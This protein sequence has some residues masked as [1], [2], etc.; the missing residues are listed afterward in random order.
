MLAMR[1]HTDPGNPGLS[2]RLRTADLRGDRLLGTP[3]PQVPVVWERHRYGQGDCELR[4][5]VISA[6]WAAQLG[7]DAQHAGYVAGAVVDV[8]LTRAGLLSVAPNFTSDDSKDLGAADAVGTAEMREGHPSSCIAGPNVV[9]LI[10]SQFGVPDLLA[11]QATILAG[12]TF[13]DF[14]ANVVVVR[15]Q[16]QVIGAHTGRVVAVVQNM[17]ASRDRPVSNDDRRD[18]RAHHPF[19]L[20]ANAH[21]AVPVCGLASGPNPTR[22]QLRTVRRNR[23]VQINAG[24]EAF[25]QSLSGLVAGALPTFN[26]AVTACLCL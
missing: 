16:K 9:D 18:V 24:P 15:A 8:I 4:R 13:L 25:S 11:T 19:P 2:G 23:P 26:R 22:P 14:I 10:A 3:A 17:H 12:P 7:H 21:A 5:T 1:L 6:E 20:P